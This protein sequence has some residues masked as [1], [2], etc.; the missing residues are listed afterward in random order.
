MDSNVQNILKNIASGNIGEM[1]HSIDPKSIVALAGGIFV[2][3][4]VLMAVKKFF[5]K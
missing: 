2:V 5:F 3:G 4:I 1:K